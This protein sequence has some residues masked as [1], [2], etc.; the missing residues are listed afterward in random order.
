MEAF[1]KNHRQHQASNPYAGGPKEHS[2]LLTVEDVKGDFAHFE[3]VEL[4]ERELNLSEGTY[5]NGK[6]A[7][8]RFIGRK[9]GEAVV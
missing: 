9:K 4:R 6:S 3:I 2:M 7:V 5:H 1:S 8:I